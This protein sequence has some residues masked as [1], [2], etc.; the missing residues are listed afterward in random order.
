MRAWP[1]PRAERDGS[2]RGR[3]AFASTQAPTAFLNTKSFYDGP[4]LRLDADC[5][6]DEGAFCEGHVFSRGRLVLAPSRVRAG[7]I[8]HPHAICWAG[9][10]VP[11]GMELGP[12]TQLLGGAPP[13][14]GAL[15]QGVPPRR[16]PPG[17]VV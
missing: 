4:L 2:R 12:R 5:V 13:G 15:V 9:D 3:S 16:V 8:L 10:D 14:V 7:A 6:V 17:Y 11:E 1:P